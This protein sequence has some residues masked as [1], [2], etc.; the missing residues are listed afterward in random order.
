M[1]TE[2]ALMRFEATLADQLGFVD[3]P[4]VET[5]ARALTAALRPATRE[6]AMELAQQAAEEVGAQVEGSDVEVVLSGGEPTLVVRQRADERESP[7][8]DDEGYEARLTLRL[9]PSIKER[10]EQAAEQTGDSVNRWVVEALSGSAR[11]ATRRG[12]RRVQGR[13]RT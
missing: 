1:D 6:L 12:R 13:V 10:I 7:P 3:D 4:A 8:P 5:A 9:P 2:S 11:P